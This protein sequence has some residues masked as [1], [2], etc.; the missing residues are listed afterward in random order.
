MPVTR[1]K[2]ICEICGDE[3]D[4]TVNQKYCPDCG[5]RPD[6]ARKR[7][8][9]A[10]QMLNRH[11]GI[12]DEPKTK[13]CSQCGKEFSTYAD[14]KFCSKKCEKQYRIEN[15]KCT[16]CG[17]KLLTLGIEHCSLTGGV[18]FC[19]D[20]CK[21]KYR[22]KRVEAGEIASRTCPH[23]SKVFSGKSTVFCSKVC[24][25]QAVANGWKPDRYKRVE[26]ACEHCNK[27]FTTSFKSPSRYCPECIVLLNK[28]RKK[29]ADAAKKKQAEEK[30]KADIEKNGLCFY[31]Q[32]THFNCEKMRTGFR[33]YP[34]GAKVVHGKVME[35]PS[36]TDKNIKKGIN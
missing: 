8:E 14:R 18:R 29:K 6:R 24:Y 17:K 22:E 32:T 4:G 30:R 23:C 36:Y 27:V 16:Y 2:K 10:Q 28:I 3:Y 33:Y 19:S 11:M 21:G 25:E 13:N 20:E 5:K 34:K 35:C 26:M 31:C 12:Y 7:Y 1:T 15:A 9:K